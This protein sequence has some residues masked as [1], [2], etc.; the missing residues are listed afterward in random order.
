MKAEERKH[1]KENELAERLGRV[2]RAVAS[3]STT[4]TIIWGVIL[5]GLAI[6]IGWRYY[7]NATFQSRSAE[8]TAV[9]RAGTAAELERIINDHPGTVV[10]RTARFH[11]NR[12][13]IDQALGHIAS[14]TSEERLKAANSLE[15]IRNSYLELA[16]V[17]TDEPELIQESL[18]Q[19]ARADE[20]LAAVPKA[21]SVLTPRETL[22]N[23]QKAYEALATR[24]P[25]S[26]LGKQAAKRAQ[27]MEEHKTQIR[28]FYDS[29][30]EVHGKPPPP[31]PLP[32][33]EPT[34]PTTVP[35]PALPDLPKAVDPK[36]VK[37]PP[38]A[39]AP[40]EKP[41]MPAPPVA[42]PTPPAGDKPA[43]APKEPKPKAP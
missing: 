32:A 1:L 11:L 37:T 8:W 41:P 16:K 6:A 3:G 22:D 33:A 25:E 35:N 5:C 9:E 24:F 14:P 36:D 2:W 39:A 10:A 42:P 31:P 13:L 4:N 40:T 38:P 23:A 18:M 43:G 27:E 12:H 28:V 17:T 20:V 19:V 34:P 26:Y 29:L 30:L 15:E 21:D 7:S